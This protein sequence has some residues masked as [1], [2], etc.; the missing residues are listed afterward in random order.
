MTP[1]FRIFRFTGYMVANTAGLF[2]NSDRGASSPSTIQ[3]INVRGILK[4]KRN[5]EGEEKENGGQLHMTVIV[6]D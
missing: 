2:A 4:E 5:S 6:F 3:N 1:G